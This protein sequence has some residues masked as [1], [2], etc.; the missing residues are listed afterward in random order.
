MA[1]SVR[2]E[3]LIDREPELTARF[4][5]L[6]EG[7]GHSQVQGP[8]RAMD[9]ADASLYWLALDTNVTRVLTVGHRDFPRCRLPDGRAFELV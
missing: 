8:R 7:P 6:D 4:R 1:V 2:M 9:L 3:R 5:P